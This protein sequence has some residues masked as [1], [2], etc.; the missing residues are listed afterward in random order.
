MKIENFS[1]RLIALS[2]LCF[3]PLTISAQSKEVALYYDVQAPQLRFAAS[4]IRSAATTQKMKIAEHSLQDFSRQIGSLNIVLLTEKEQKR[5]PASIKFPNNET[6]QSYAI[7]VQRSNSQTTFF[8]IGADAVGALYGGLDLAEAIRNNTVR[9]LKDSDHQPHIEKRG[10]KFNLPLDAR[11]PSYSDNSDSAQANIPE[12]WSVDFW[13]EYLDEMARQRYNVLSLWNLHPFPSMV[14][15]PEYPQVALDDVKRTTFKMDDSF[16]HRGEDMARPDVLKNLETIKKISIDEKIKFWRDVMQYA[17]DRGIETYLFTW[18]M[19]VWG[20]EGKHGITGAQDNPITIDYFRKSVRETILTYPL[21]AGIGITAGERLQDRKDEFGKEKWLWKTYGEGIGDALKEQP[22]R[23]FRLIHRFHET[24][25]SEIVDEFKELPAQLDL[26]FKYAIAHMYSTPNPPFIKAA[27]PHLSPKLR[28]WLTLRN[29]DIYSFRWGNAEY[30]REFIQHIPGKDKVA[31]F[32]MGPD[33]YIWGREFL[34]TE[35]DT[36]RQ[37]VMQKQWYSFMLWGRLSYE[38]TLPDTV[39]AGTLAQRF[40]ATDIPVLMKAWSESSKIIPQITRFFWGDIDLRWF[41]EACLSDK[42]YKGWY[43]VRHFIEG[44]TMPESGILN[45]LEWRRNL[46]S[47]APMNG[48]TPLQVAEA[49]QQHAVESLSRTAQLSLQQGINKELRLTLGDMEAMSHLG[50][51]YA[52]KIRGACELALYDKT[53]QTEHREA[54][55]KQLEEALKQWRNYA[56]I[57]AQQ[58]KPQLLNRVGFVDIPGFIANVERDIE[59]ARNWKPGTIKDEA[60]QKT[61]ADNPFKP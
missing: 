53:S 50:L 27:L 56:G 26:S 52:A 7:R 36:P 32:Y 2:L 16:S 17:H 21:L 30:A 40:P 9:D 49:L 18:N 39:F 4:E 11:T 42:S 44:Q 47:K 8:V 31:G 41:P 45:V 24:A 12:I 38:P 14:K 58:Y 29:D 28:S 54:A 61:S 57:Y 13:H 1:L 23:K 5:L 3:I 35:P 10:I 43:T 46:T 55:I 20:A 22:Q 51:Y 25:Q 6:P 15:V 59:I 37:L 60:L 34:S 48:I 19:F 33:G